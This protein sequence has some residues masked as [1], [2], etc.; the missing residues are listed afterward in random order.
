MT[1]TETTESS[2]MHTG[3][4][5]RYIICKTTTKNDKNQGS[6]EKKNRRFVC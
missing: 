1:P 2:P 6:L 4:K 5:N 3:D